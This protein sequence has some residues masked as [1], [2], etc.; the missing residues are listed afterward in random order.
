MKVIRQ[1]LALPLLAC[2]VAQAGEN[3]AA[4]DSAAAGRFGAA[5]AAVDSSTPELLA[6][7]E[8]ATMANQWQYQVRMN[9]S[10]ELADAY[11]QGRDTPALA[12]LRDALRRHNATITSQYD[13]FARYVA[14]AEREGV[15]NFPLYQWTVDTISDPDK[16]AK[17]QRV[18]TVYVHDQEVYAEDVANALQADLSALGQANGVLS[19]NKFDT[20]PEHNPQPPRKG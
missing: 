15:Q 12:R 14:E 3:P 10:Q 18:F 8:G 20:N 9:V 6:E 11:R 4:A 5:N 13:A 1:L 2:A 19:I 17:Y 7:K 16:R